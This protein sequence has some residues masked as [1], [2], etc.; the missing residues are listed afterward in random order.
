LYVLGLLNSR[1]LDTVVKTT[2]SPFR[3]GYYAYNK[4]YIQHLPIRL[5]DFGDPGDRARHDQMVTLV[6]EML[7]L[8]AEHAEAERHKEDRRHDLQRR[9]EEIDRAIDALVYD[10]YGLT[11]EEI[12]LVEGT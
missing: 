7:R 12:R 11:E 1:L 3:H 2:S 4:Q 5:I 6:E 10:L 8:Q 9:I